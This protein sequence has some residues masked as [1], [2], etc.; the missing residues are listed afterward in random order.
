M[1][2]LLKIRV[3]P[4]YIYQ[5]DPIPGSAHFRTP[6]EKGVE[7]IHSLRGY[8]SGYAV[9]TYVIDAP[10]GGGKI[11][12]S[13]DYVAGRNKDCLLLRNYEGKLYQY[14]D[15]LEKVEICNYNNPDEGRENF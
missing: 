1:H 12:V 15:S 8:T 14:P 5:C 2:G 6:V 4:Y 9:P 11:P 3:K 13:P 7:I 10:G